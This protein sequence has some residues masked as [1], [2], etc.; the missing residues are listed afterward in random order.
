MD[1]IYAP[2]LLLDH[3]ASLR[4][5]FVQA[6]SHEKLPAGACYR[7]YETQDGTVLLESPNL[8]AIVGRQPKAIETDPQGLHST[9]GWLRGKLALFVQMKRS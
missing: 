2:D 4:F 3:T 5:A 8:F 9:P 6:I 7:S 1:A